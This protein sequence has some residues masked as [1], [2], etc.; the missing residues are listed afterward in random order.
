MNDSKKA[1]LTWQGR[2][3]PSVIPS[4]LIRVQKTLKIQGA[5]PGKIAVPQATPPPLPLF[6]LPS[7][8]ET[9]PLH[10]KGCNP[11]PTNT[12]NS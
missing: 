3:F 9:G 5:L 1:L 10:T 8:P 12:E 6:S 11:A 7:L 4:D 2:S